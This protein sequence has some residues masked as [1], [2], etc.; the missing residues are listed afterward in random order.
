PDDLVIISATPIPGNE[1][2][3]SRIVN[4]ILENGTEVIYESLADV[5]VS[6]HACQEELKVILALVKPKYFIPV[7]GEQRHLKVHADISESMGTEKENI[8]LLD[9]GQTLEFTKDGASLGPTVQAGNILVDGL[10]VGDVGNIVLR[11]RKHLS[12]DGLIVVV[13]T[14]SKQDGTVISGPDIVSRGF[15]YVRESEDLMEE[16]RNIVR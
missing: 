10:G 2:T 16:A 11:D 1:K 7:H 5:H 15:V 9:N 8:F 14:M 13:V 4:K 6:G 12:E 3:V